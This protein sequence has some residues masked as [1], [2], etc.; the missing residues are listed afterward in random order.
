MPCLCVTNSLRLFIRTIGQVELPATIPQAGRNQFYN[1]SI[2]GHGLNRAVRFQ[3]S[4]STWAIISTQPSNLTTPGEHAITEEASTS[5]NNPSISLKSLLRDHDTVPEETREHRSR[6]APQNEPHADIAFVE[7]SPESIDALAAEIESQTT[8]RRNSLGANSIAQELQ[9]SRSLK[10]AKARNDGGM[11]RSVSFDRPAVA[12]K[13]DKTEWRFERG[14][15]EAGNQRIKESDPR[16]KREEWQIQKEA[17]KNK[18]PD[19]WNPR[20]RLSPDALAGIRALHAQIPDQYSTTEL[21]KT[22]QVSPEAIRRILKGKWTPNVDEEMDRQRRWFKR[23]EQVW[24]RYAELGVKPPQ[25][26]RELGIGRGRPDKKK[27][28]VLVT[29]STRS[30]ETAE[31]EAEGDS[32]AD[33]IL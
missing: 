19:A 18:F 21:A 13:Q 3:H 28:P 11:M 4:S 12:A 25:R 26:W 6:N 27:P 9:S 8:V 23:G 14:V 16:P 20:K 5:E 32:L 17:L 15:K 31:D 22:F 30:R 33:R 2:R 29:T 24:S 1:T 10:K 7:L